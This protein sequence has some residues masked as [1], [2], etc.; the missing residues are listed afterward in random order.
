MSLRE[1]GG[2]P[3]D[4]DSLSASSLE[5]NSEYVA[6]IESPGLS[7]QARVL[8]MAGRDYLEKMFAESRQQR[9]DVEA[10]YHQKIA[11]ARAL[12]GGESIIDIFDDPEAVAE[13][14][15]ANKAAMEA[16]SNMFGT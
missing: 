3:A 13:R 6:H 5:R 9:S 10:K 15:A 14:E 12:I 11:S 2:T 8:L 1:S 4:W 16:M 7:P